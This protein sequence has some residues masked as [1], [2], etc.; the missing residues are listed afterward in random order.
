MQIHKSFLLKFVENEGTKFK[1]MKEE[2]VSGERKEKPKNNCR[3][4]SL[5]NRLPEKEIR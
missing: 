3:M 1:I 2:V 4:I 5:N